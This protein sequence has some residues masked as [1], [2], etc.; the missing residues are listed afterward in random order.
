MNTIYHFGNKLTSENYE[1]LRKLAQKLSYKDFRETADFKQGIFT[2][3]RKYPKFEDY[4][5]YTAE[6]QKKYSPKNGQ[7]ITLKDI[8]EK[9]LKIEKKLV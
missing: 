4:K 2:R 8:Y 3:L 7:K 6:N 9:L 1:T 5:N